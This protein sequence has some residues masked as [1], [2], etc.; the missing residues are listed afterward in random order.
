MTAV[1]ES[2]FFKML[3]FDFWKQGIGNTEKQLTF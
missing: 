1:F 2:I 3:R